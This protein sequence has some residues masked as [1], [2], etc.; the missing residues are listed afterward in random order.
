[1]SNCFVIQPFDG[2]RFDKR[3][4]DVFAPAITEAGLTPYRVD[5]DPAVTIPIEEIES[6]I[7]NAAVCLVDITLDNPNVWFE[8]GYAIA[9]NKSVILVCAKERTTRFPFDVQHRSIIRYDSESPRDFVTLQKGI[10][11]RIGA[12]MTK[13]E[14]LEKLSNG[15]TLAQIEGLNQQ[16]LITLASIAEN[17]HTPDAVVSAST[18]RR[19]VESAGFTRMA[20]TLGMKRLLNKEFITCTLIYDRDDDEQYPY[21]QITDEGW[22][23]IMNNEEKFQIR[24]PRDADPSF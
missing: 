2:G 4:E 19:D 7:R 3:F 10:V 22:S 23:W 13:A 24:R 18:V 21:Y 16:E 14:T 15:T 8:L 12:I 20:A 17:L 11:E 6:G 9:A 5:R 1:M